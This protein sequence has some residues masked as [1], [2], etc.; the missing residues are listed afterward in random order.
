VKRYGLLCFFIV[1]LFMAGTS[2]DVISNITG[3]VSSKPVATVTNIHFST[4]P[5]ATHVVFDVQV[6]PNGALPDTSYYVCLLSRDGYYF[7]SLGGR[8]IVRW[9]G[10][11][12]QGSDENERDYYK[13]KEVEERM[14]K[15][16]TLGAPLTD[17]DI[18]ALREDCKI[19]AEKLAEAY[20]RELWG[21]LVGGDLVELFKDA[22]KD[23]ELTQSEINRIFNKH[24][25]LVVVDKEGYLKLEYPDG[26]ILELGVFSGQGSFRTP[27]FTPNHKWLRI[28][29]LSPTG[30][31][32]EGGLYYSDGRGSQW[33]TFHVWP[34]S[35]DKL[36]SNR[37]S[38]Q[39]GAE[40]YYTF[41]IQDDMVWQLKIEES[42]MDTWIEEMK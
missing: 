35:E 18:V 11:E 23:P 14:T 22:G 9:T 13:I 3:Q 40:Y 8:E 27:N 32:G 7:G 4:N 6:E 12:L 16:F 15:R 24:L 38:V 36:F 29:I 34:D 28:T 25:K 30:C 37:L 21:D 19:E 41:N 2:C 10:E 33:G 1:A 20:A 26:E 17:K 5:N 39:P 42:N 31:M